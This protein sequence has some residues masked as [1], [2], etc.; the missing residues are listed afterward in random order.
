VLMVTPRLH[1]PCSDLDLGMGCHVATDCPSHSL[2]LLVMTGCCCCPLP[3]L[4][5][6]LPTLPAQQRL[7]PA[8]LAMEEVPLIPPLRSGG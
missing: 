1:C 8:G 3:F 4:A 5:A 2:G 7:G 6:A